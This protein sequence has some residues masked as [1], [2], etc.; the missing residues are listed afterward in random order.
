VSIALL[1]MTIGI[2]WMRRLVAR[3]ED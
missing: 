3:V 1:L 2:F